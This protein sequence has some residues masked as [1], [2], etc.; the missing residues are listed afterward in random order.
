MSAFTLYAPSTHQLSAL[1]TALL[2]PASGI[3]VDIASINLKFGTGT[4]FGT[5]DINTLD[6]SIF[7]PDTFDP[8]TF[9][10][11]I[12]VT[13]DTE[14]ASLSFYDGSIASLG[15]GAGLLLTSGDA[16]PPV[17][18]TEGGYG[19]SLTPSETDVD[20]NTSV[21]AA[22]SGAGDV[23]D[24]TVLEFQF[25]V[26]DPS[27]TSVKFDLIFG[28]DEFPEFTDSSFV[29]IAGV[30]VNGVNYALFNNQANQPLSILGTNQA[31]GNFRD[32][33]ATII[34]LEYD[35]ISN[36]LSIVA[37]VHAGVN[38][39][40][41]AIAD[42]GDQILDSGLFIGNV[43]A[44]NFSGAGL[45]LQTIG[46]NGNDPFVLGNDFNELFELGD[47]NDNVQGGLGDDVL[48]GGNGFDAAIFSGA[49]SDY[50]LQKTASGQTISGP[51]GNDVLIDIEFALFGNDL[52][53]LDTQ[54]GNATYNTYGLL[55]AAFNTA[56]S[57]DLL[58]EW[59]VK[60]MTAANTAALAQNMIDT[61]APGLTNDTLV[62]HLYQTIAGITPTQAQIDELSTQIGP[63]NTFGTQGD[64]FAFAAGLNLNTDEFAS[65][66]GTSLALDLGHFI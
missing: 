57:T 61:L 52:F 47:G 26:G 12:F 46:T 25:T 38:N 28:S 27:L 56:P 55:Q 59:V 43:K 2:T 53:A 44:V 48:N 11:S 8:N 7:D 20:L 64:F 22:F 23:Q 41:I 1:T 14:T 62:T 15:I 39:M 35:G 36:L 30:Y 60:E 19:Q 9:D 45:A 49:L 3:T 13:T 66:V 42:T 29:D 18:N 40:K 24:A 10:P 37:P 58:S 50:T 31:A 34:P 5:I 33:A 51:D 17:T 54:P 21:Q 4:K 16:D 63:G 6:P 32:N 65:I